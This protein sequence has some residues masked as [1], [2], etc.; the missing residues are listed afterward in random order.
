[1][2]RRIDFG[3]VDDDPIAIGEDLT[4]R[5]QMVKKNSAGADIVEGD[6][7]GN[8]Y[9]MTVKK[10][11]ADSAALIDLAT[12]SEITFDAG[13]SDPHN[14]L[15]GANTVLVIA[16]NDTETELIPEEGL[17]HFDVWRT[18]SGDESLVVFGTI[19]FVKAVRVLP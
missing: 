8:A 17:Y 4:F 12:G 9:L 6:V 2:A 7:S 15:A 3:D 14:E 13:I 18:D 5:I 19:H 16:M 1:M 10:S 11:P